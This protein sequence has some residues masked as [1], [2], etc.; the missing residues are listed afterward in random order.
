MMKRKILAQVGKRLNSI[1][2]TPAQQRMKERRQHYHQ[3]NSHR[4]GS[5]NARF[6][7]YRPRTAE[8]IQDHFKKDALIS[9][10]HFQKMNADGEYQDYVRRHQRAYFDRFFESQKK[11]KCWYE[12]TLPTSSTKVIHTNS[13]LLYDDRFE[14]AHD[15]TLEFPSSQAGEEYEGEKECLLVSNISPDMSIETFSGLFPGSPKISMGLPD[16]QKQ[17]Y[18]YAWVHYDENDS[19]AGLETL[20]KCLNLEAHQLY[21]CVDTT[22]HVLKGRVSQVTEQHVDDLEAAFKLR[23]PQ[24]SLLDE[25]TLSSWEEKLDVMAQHERINN[26]FCIFCGIQAACKEELIQ[27]CGHAHWRS[28]NPQFPLLDLSIV[29]ERTALYTS[30]DTFLPKRDAGTLLDL[31]FIRKIEEGKFQCRQ[32]EKLFKGPEFVTKHYLMKH[33]EES[34][35]LR[36][37]TQLYDQFRSDAR[38]AGLVWPASMLLGRK[39]EEEERGGRSFDRRPPGPPPPK[40]EYRDWDAVSVKEEPISY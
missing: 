15:G 6:A 40:R 5:N 7:P 16:P 22:K 27:R 32:C 30:I 14:V 33:V 20:L 35:R 2:T 4:G 37:E 13:K 19:P 34:E 39:D 36:L 18:R 8:S 11:R 26:H 9:K 29:K 24:T 38:L 28:T 10:G 17:F 23:N 21:A 1:K 3:H 12:L 31:H 25:S